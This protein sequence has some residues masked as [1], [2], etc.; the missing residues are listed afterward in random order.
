V[1][2]TIR[3]K[4]GLRDPEGNAIEHALSALGWQGVRNVH[5]G[6]TIS[7]DVPASDDDTARSEAAEMCRRILANPVIEDFE[8]EVGDGRA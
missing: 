3:P 5:V 4:S 2:V 1:T 8:I 7:L 6:K